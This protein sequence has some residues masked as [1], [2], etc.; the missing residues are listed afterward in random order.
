MKMLGKRFKNLS[1]QNPLEK[2]FSQKRL[3]S[4]NLIAY[5]Y[6]MSLIEEGD[7]I[8]ICISEHHN[9]IVPWQQVAKHKSYIK[10]PVYQPEF[11]LGY[12]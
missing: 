8:V 2:S 6:G 5:S 7:E 10:I 11:Y 12:G 3:G 4:T 1:M 9:N